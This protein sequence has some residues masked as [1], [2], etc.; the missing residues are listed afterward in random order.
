MVQKICC[1][2]TKTTQQ[3]QQAIKQRNIMHYG[4]SNEKR[5]TSGTS[6]NIQ[7]RANK[8]HIL[9]PVLFGAI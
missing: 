7:Q 3:Q 1:T 6:L 9:V 4:L 2:Y 8:T 5:H